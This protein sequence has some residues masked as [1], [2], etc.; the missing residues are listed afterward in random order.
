MDIGRGA[1][2]SVALITL[3]ALVVLYVRFA[4]GNDVES[5]ENGF[6]AVT[7]DWCGH[8]KNLKKSGE[9][10][11]LAKSVP[12]MVLD[13]KDPGASD[14]M[15]KLGAKGYPAL[16]F[17]NGSEYTPYHGPRKASDILKVMNAN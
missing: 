13:E 15:A 5:F 7:A 10:D 16:G 17:V 11:K 14:V 4:K 8:C 6:V 12:V 3:I 9:L 1:V 2:A